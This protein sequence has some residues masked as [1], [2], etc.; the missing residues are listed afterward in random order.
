MLPTCC[1][2]CEF[3]QQNYTNSDTRIGQTKF[4][5]K[6]ES[7]NKN[8]EAGRE[9]VR[10]GGREARRQGGRQPRREAAEAGR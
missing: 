7:E 8:R 9:A 2:E 5:A 10:Q 4:V 6:K 1:D 3:C